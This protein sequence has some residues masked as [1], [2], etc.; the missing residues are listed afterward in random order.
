MTYISAER[1]GGI[2][3]FCDD[4]IGLFSFCFTQDQL[5]LAHLCGKFTLGKT[6]KRKNFDGAWN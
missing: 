5:M 3:L 4:D 2:S 6:Q 1:Q